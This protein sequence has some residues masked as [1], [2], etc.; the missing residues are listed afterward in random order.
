MNTHSVASVI[1]VFQQWSRGLPWQR[2]SSAANDAIQGILL[3]R[4]STEKGSSLLSGVARASAPR[5]RRR[6]AHANMV[7]FLQG[8]RARTGWRNLEMV[9]WRWEVGDWRLVRF[10]VMILRFETEVCK[11]CNTIGV[12]LWRT[13]VMNSRSHK[14]K[15]RFHRA[16]PRANARWLESCVSNVHQWFL[17]WDKRCVTDVEIFLADNGFESIKPCV[18]TEHVI[19]VRVHQLPLPFLS[20]IR[21]SR[22]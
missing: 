5:P 15:T 9:V 6:I 3:W 4:F 7:V 13:S 17:C 14:G 12:A 1:A 2:R 19:S 22:A 18:A 20:Q 8:G 10:K 21:G 11:G 16:P